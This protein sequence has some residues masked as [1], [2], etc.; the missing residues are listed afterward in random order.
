MRTND[1]MWAEVS[2]DLDAEDHERIATM[3]RSIVLPLWPYL[4]A[5]TT[6]EEF[7]VRRSLVAERVDE[8]TDTLTVDNPTTRIAVR[9]EVDRQMVTDFDVLHTSRLAEVQTRQAEAARLV[10]IR[11]AAA[12]QRV[13]V[14]PKFVVVDTTDGQ[15]HHHDSDGEMFSVAS[16]RNFADKRNAGMKPAYKQTFT[17]HTLHEANISEPPPFVRES[18][19]HGSNEV[20]GWFVIQ[21]GTGTRSAG[22][23]DS[24]EEARSRASEYNERHGTNDQLAI[25][26]GYR[27]IT[28]GGDASSEY[29]RK[30]IPTQLRDAGHTVT[31]KSR[32]DG[33]QNYVVNGEEMSLRDAADKFLGGWDNAFG[34]KGAAKLPPVT[35]PQPTG[36]CKVC[37]GAVHATQTPSGWGAWVHDDQ[38][39]GADHHLRLAEGSQHMA[40]TYVTTGEWGVAYQGPT[41]SSA[42]EKLTPSDKKW[43]LHVYKTVDEPNEWGGIGISVKHPDHYGK[44]FDSQDDATAYAVQHGLLREWKHDRERDRTSAI[45]RIAV[46]QVHTFG[47]TGEAYNRS[48]TDDNIKDGDILHVP[49]EGVV[50]YLHAAWPV[51][52]TQEHGAF[53]S[54]TDPAAGPQ[55]EPA[56]VCQNCGGSGKKSPD[57]HNTFPNQPADDDRCWG[58][59]GQGGSKGDSPERV[60]KWRS[61]WQQAQDI[62]RQSGYHTA[63]LHMGIEKDDGYHLITPYRAPCQTCAGTGN[64]VDSEGNDDRCPVCNGR[65]WTDPFVPE[66]NASLHT[67]TPPA[68]S[69]ERH[70]Q[71]LMHQYALPRDRAE[72]EA[73]DRYAKHPQEI[74]RWQAHD[75]V[76]SSLD[77]EVIL[78]RAEAAVDDVSTWA[79]SFGIWHARVTEGNN[80]VGDS[81]G[82]EAAARS[83]I[84][85]ELQQREGPKFAPESIGVKLV[86]RTSH[87]GLLESEFVEIDPREGSL[88]PEHILGRAEAAAATDADDYKTKQQWIVQGRKFNDMGDQVVVRADSAEEAMMLARVK[89]GWKFADSASPREGSLHA[90]AGLNDPAGQ[91]WIYHEGGEDERHRVD[92][93]VL[94]AGGHVSSQRWADGHIHE[95]SSV[96]DDTINGLGYRPQAGQFPGNRR[97]IPLNKVKQLM[98]EGARTAE[99]RM[100]TPAVHISGP[101]R[102][103]NH[104]PYTV[105]QV[106]SP[107]ESM[108]VSHHGSPEEA[109]AAAFAH[110]R[111]N[112]MHLYLDGEEVMT[113]K[114]SSLHEATIQVRPYT[115]GNTGKSDV[116]GWLV[117]GRHPKTQRQVK[118]FFENEGA[119]RSHAEKLRASDQDDIDID[120]GNGEVSKAP[121]PLPTTDAEWRARESSLRIAGLIQVC[122]HGRTL[123]EG[124]PQCL[125]EDDWH[126][127]DRASL[128]PAV[129]LARAEAAAQTSTDDTTEEVTQG[130]EKKPPQPTTTKPRQ[131][132]GAGPSGAVQGFGE[133]TKTTAVTAETEEERRRRHRRRCMYCTQPII[134]VGGLGAGWGHV[135]SDHH[136]PDGQHVATPPEAAP[137]APTEAP[138]A[139][140]TASLFDRL[141]KRRARRAR[142][143]L[144]R[145]AIVQSDGYYVMNGEQAIAGPFT[146]PSEAE[147]AL[148]PGTPQ[149]IE[150]RTAGEVWGE[151]DD[152]EPFENPDGWTPGNASVGAE[153]ADGGGGGSSEVYL[154]SLEAKVT[155]IT[156]SILRTNPGMNRNAAHNIAVETV[157]RFP[158]V[159]AGDRCSKCG[160]PATAVFANADGKGTHFL[161]PRHAAEASQQTTAA[162]PPVSGNGYS[163]NAWTHLNPRNPEHVKQAPDE[164]LLDWI[165]QGAREL[166]EPEARRRNIYGS[167]RH[168]AMDV[169]QDTPGNIRARCPCGWSSV[170]PER[171]VQDEIDQHMRDYH[172]EASLHRLAWG[173]A[174]AP[175]Q[176]A[177]LRSYCQDRWDDGDKWGSAMDCLG[178]IADV[179]THL[180]ESVM[181]EIG[182][183][184]GMGGPDM[185]EDSSGAWFKEG[186]DAGQFD[187]ND[188]QQ[189]SQVLHTLCDQ[190]DAAG[191]SY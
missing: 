79:D 95:F 167:L 96:A 40:K 187:V 145:E 44:E 171:D 93:A 89:Y 45:K 83:A 101:S 88:N 137:E 158:V 176:N 15:V 184:P 49:S 157:E 39:Q 37:G 174:L 56:R 148:Q 156:D 100:K 65:G 185:G 23:F 166:A 111:K 53:H 146:T 13:A 87:D 138:T 74:E 73:Q 46:A 134:W 154:S 1:D 70:V 162:R 11:R 117:S 4:A 2:R 52:A 121:P 97:G 80:A 76:T 112:N 129:T 160:A 169:Q 12:A 179:L 57:S 126:V 152:T 181:P 31:T 61:S 124:C 177:A 29:T 26:L 182:Y 165:R 104:P 92:R 72:A 164:K 17:V 20:S 155:E 71:W 188:L 60:A 9:A 110:A 132:P 27:I 28:V 47:S 108:W 144:K 7:D 55:G 94:D 62:A 119:A 6:T 18:A 128:D 69:H 67:A 127:E 86:T 105:H 139:P 50:G 190:L 5:A 16:A 82:A 78:R 84:I 41:S 48:Q 141:R 114:E 143:T 142:R 175:I 136:C 54:L 59:S 140:A 77:P 161:C 120:W 90:N 183:S 22:P 14:A 163:P 63:S 98:R 125:G 51:A 118:I 178:G 43:K 81:A 186:L 58:C 34:S 150:Y 30:S 36:T 25:K 106:N 102:S 99:K 122:R 66:F 21:R 191:E 38:A 109:E 19:N 64:M 107:A 68:P 135:G 151:T 103:S 91:S 180:G 32:P 8:A 115:Q 85:D 153:L 130:F 147:Q 75:H 168:V 3:A 131:K 189:A 170:G 172:H 159:A 149:T 116:P 42:P 33:G 113:R 133:P 123:T 173:E 35:D 10:A 24:E